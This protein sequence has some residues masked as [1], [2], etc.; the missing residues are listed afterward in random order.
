MVCPDH[1]HDWRPMQ[2][3]KDCGVSV[4]VRPTV[5][6]GWLWA[7]FM[8]GVVIVYVV[9]GLSGLLDEGGE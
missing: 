9:L 4:S 6:A 5:S 3:C 7:S 2:M 8:L 1:N